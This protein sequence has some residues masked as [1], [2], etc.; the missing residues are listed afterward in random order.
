MIDLATIYFLE[1]LTTSFGVISIILFF[2]A[3]IINEADEEKEHTKEKRIMAILS[4][5]FMVLFILM[6]SSRTFKKLE[7]IELKKLENNTTIDREQKIIK[8]LKELGE[9]K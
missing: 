1:D 4:M 5:I 3:I 7:S 8:L 9:N 6:P 2:I